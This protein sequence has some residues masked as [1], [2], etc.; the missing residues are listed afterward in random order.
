MPDRTG[1]SSAVEAHGTVHWL[2]HKD[3]PSRVVEAT[4]GVRARL[5]RPFG[6]GR[7]AYVA[8]HDGVEALYLREIAAAGPGRAPQSGRQGHGSR[9]SSRRCPG[10]PHRPADPP[11]SGAGMPLPSPCR[12]PR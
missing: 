3:G 6:D 8:D 5:P 12:P 4:P 2:R 7:I 1:G 11:E 10:Q 9:P